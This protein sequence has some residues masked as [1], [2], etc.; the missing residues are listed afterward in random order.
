MGS[1]FP[2]KIFCQWFLNSYLKKKVDQCFRFDTVEDQDYSFVRIK[3]MKTFVGVI[4]TC[5][6]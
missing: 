5:I 1:F 6:S 4:A 3:E 2:A